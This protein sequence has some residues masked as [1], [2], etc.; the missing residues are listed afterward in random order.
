MESVRYTSGLMVK[1][2]LFENRFRGNGIYI[3]D[4]PEAALSPTRQMAL[5][6]LMD[7]LVKKN[8]QFIIATHSP[9]L[10]SFPDSDIFE[11]SNLGIVKTTFKECE[12]YKLYREFINNHERLIMNLLN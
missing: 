11:L 5:L 7:N 6:T 3:L 8:S 10:L 12:L 9:I 4:E 2:F 1:V